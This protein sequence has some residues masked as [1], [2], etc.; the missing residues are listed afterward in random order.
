M[1]TDLGTF[2]AAD[3]LPNLR[4]YLDFDRFHLVGKALGGYIVPGMA[5]SH[6]PEPVFP[7]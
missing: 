2:L 3:D 7:A 5:I 4:K 6:P 1:S